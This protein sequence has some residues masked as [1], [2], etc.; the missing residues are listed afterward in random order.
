[1]KTVNELL[2]YAE[3]EI[4]RVPTGAKFLVKDLFKGYEWNLIPIKDRLLLGSLFLNFVNS[5]TD[6]IVP[7]EKTSSGQQQ[8]R[9]IDSDGVK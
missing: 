8:Y 9:K 3:N 1:M 6:A 4:S 7:L 5:G 2:F